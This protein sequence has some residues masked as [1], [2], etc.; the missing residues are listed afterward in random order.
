MTFQ[1]RVYARSSNHQIKHFNRRIFI[2]VRILNLFVLS[3]FSNADDHGTA[4]TIARAATVARTD[5]ADVG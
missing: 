2:D 1:T 3:A 5:G 4:A